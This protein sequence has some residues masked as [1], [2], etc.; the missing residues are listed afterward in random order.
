V[1]IRPAILKLSLI[2]LVGGFY[3]GIGFTAD[4]IP[5]KIGLQDAEDIVTETQRGWKQST[6]RIGPGEA[7]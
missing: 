6:L 1:P 7:V 3:G 4:A 2:E 5:G